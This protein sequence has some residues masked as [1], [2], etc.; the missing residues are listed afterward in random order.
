MPYSE[1]AISGKRMK[2]SAPGHENCFP[3]HKHIN[4]LAFSSRFRCKEHVVCVPIY[5][6][7]MLAYET[8]YVWIL[9]TPNASICHNVAVR[10]PNLS[11]EQ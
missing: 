4:I 10:K 9:F 1:D 2:Y 7:K 6:I 8:I 5:A 3:A 11:F